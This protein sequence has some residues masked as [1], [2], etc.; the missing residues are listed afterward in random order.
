[1]QCLGL[2][3]WLLE[4]GDRNSFSLRSFPLRAKLFLEKFLAQGCSSQ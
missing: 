2:V 3:L 1:M 4:L